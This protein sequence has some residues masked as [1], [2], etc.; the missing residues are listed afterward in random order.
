MIDYQVSR[1]SSPAADLLYMIFNCTDHATRAKHYHD[2]ID[3]YHT[4]LGERLATYRL[5]ANYAYPRDK[6][7][8]DLRRFAKVTLGQCVMIASALV[9]A[10][11]EVAK[12]KEVMSAVDENTTMEEMS[13]MA[14]EVKMSNSNSET[15]KKF[16]ERVEGLVDSFIDF[17]YL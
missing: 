2:W 1:Q 13:K 15:I 17:G 8:A 7:D 3:Y 6:L 12:F 5:K 16:R 11:E 10:S 9:K 14:D 4:Q